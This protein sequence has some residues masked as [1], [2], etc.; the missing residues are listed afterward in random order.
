VLA[1]DIHDN[2]LTLRTLRRYA[3]GH[4]TVLAGDFTINGGRAETP[5]LRAMGAVGR[6]VVAVSGNHDSPGVMNALRRR[7]VTVLDHTDGVRTIAG[8]AMT[9]FEDPLM[10][11]RPDFPDGIRAG[12]D[13][14]S[15][16]DGE[17]RFLAAVQ[18]RWAW[19]RRLPSRPDVL[20]V[21]QAAIGRALANRIWEAD[22]DGPALAILVGHTHQQRLDRYGPVTVVDSGSIGAG[23]LFGIGSDVG[24][25]MLDFTA[26]GELEGVDLVSQNPSTSAARA[27]RIITAHPD[28][29]RDAGGLP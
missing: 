29:R 16:P 24:L 23:G 11:P 17:E 19:R 4:L 14:G 13:F 21:H 18:Q 1:S 12:I 27:R 15:F 2:L 28:W 9:G 26:D 3:A 20:I 8:L 22:P 6:P 5:L 25:A 7:G 10:S